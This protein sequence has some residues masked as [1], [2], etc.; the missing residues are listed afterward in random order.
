MWLVIS[1]LTEIGR[2]CFQEFFCITTHLSQ[3]ET[4]RIH[5]EVDS[6]GAPSESLI[7]SNK[8]W[9]LQMRRSDCRLQFAKEHNLGKMTSIKTWGLANLGAYIAACVT[10]HPSTMVEYS[11]P[12]AERSTILFGHASS[13]KDERTDEDKDND[14]YEDE[15]LF[16]PWESGPKLRDPLAAHAAPWSMILGAITGPV[17]CHS[18]LS[19]RLLYS[20]FCIRLMLGIGESTMRAPMIAALDTLAKSLKTSLSTEIESLDSFEIV[21]RDQEKIVEVV[22]SF[23]RTRS[24]LEAEIPINQRLLEYCQISECSKPLLYTSNIYKTRCS[25]GHIWSTLLVH[26]SSDHS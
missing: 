9:N 4:F 26:L 5:T 3:M 1:W 10:V 11:M 22:N 14:E 24:L 17:L 12:S 7:R 6:S 8:L 13:L 25:V 21:S 20:S 18:I 2:C 19:C 15:K 16:F 23:V